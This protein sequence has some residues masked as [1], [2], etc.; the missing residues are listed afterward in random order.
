[1]SKNRRSEAR[2][3]RRSVAVAGLVVAAHAATVVGWAT[4]AH[5]APVTDRV[6][7]ANAGQQAN[8]ASANPSVN[9]D[10][11]LI[12]FS[13]SATNLTDVV[14]S[15]GQVY[16]RHTASRQTELVSRSTAGGAANGDALDPSISEDGRLVAFQSDASNLVPGDTNG[17]HDIFVRDRATGV[18][19]RISVSTAGGQGNAI[20]AQPAI[21][22]DGRYVAFTSAASNLVSGDTNGVGDI[23]VH[24]RALGQT[25]RASVGPAGVEG[26]GN[27]SKPSINRDGSRVAFHSS[28]RNLTARADTNSADDV[29]VA[30]RTAVLLR[31]SESSG[32][33][34]GN[35][36]SRDAA[37][38]ADGRTVVYQSAANN[39]VGGDTNSRRDVFRHDVINGLTTLVS[40][41]GTGGAANGD[42]LAPSIS[43]DG[44]RV[45]YSSTASNLVGTDANGATSDV[46]VTD[47]AA[48]PGAQN[49]LVSVSTGG[50]AANGTSAFSALS[51]NG[52][53]TAYHSSATNL[54]AGDTNA[55]LDVFARNS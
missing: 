8:G 30:S 12:A 2:A 16:V 17:V 34:Q 24:D 18:T 39:L 11:S 9:L 10:G 22:G 54:V 23:F 32:S 36:S 44:R 45:A 48:A 35:L 14:V 50:T 25:T 4:A 13:S 29:F 5:A 1:M 38:S 3:L 6:S 27:S 26:T 51:H 46:F 20:S 53:V 15:P 42:S 41:A 37:I 28:A 31:A 43:A 40:A 52:L 55:T 7:V 21:S 49:T 47:L 33:V 19:T